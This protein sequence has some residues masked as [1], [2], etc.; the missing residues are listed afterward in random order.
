MRLSCTK[1]KRRWR[2]RKK[3]RRKRRKREN[4]GERGEK[5]GEKRSL[6]DLACS[7]ASR[8]IGSVLPT[9]S[10]PSTLP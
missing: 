6:A 4:R 8:L 7:E 5:K 2:R 3:R 1:I 9:L 10:H